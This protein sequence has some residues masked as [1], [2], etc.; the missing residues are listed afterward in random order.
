MEK[1]NERA[2]KTTD[3]NFVPLPVMLAVAVI[4]FWQ[5]KFSNVTN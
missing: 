1:K 2:H 5:N 3:N 4:S